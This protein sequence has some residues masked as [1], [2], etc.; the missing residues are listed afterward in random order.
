VRLRALRLHDVRRF[1]GEGIALEGVADGLNCLIR[2]NEFGKTTLLEAFEALL[3]VKHGSRAKEAAGLKPRAGGAP[4]VSADIDLPDARVTVRKR[5]LSRPMAQVVDR[6]TGAVI[7]NGDA[8][9]DWLSA[10]IGGAGKETPLALFWVR[11]GR[12]ALLD[13]GAATR[14][15]ALD[16]VIESEFADLTG[17]DRLRRLRERAQGEIAA[18]LTPQRR[19]P[20]ADGPLGRA[21]A[22]RDALA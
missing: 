4:T 7:A 9:Q 10:R 1:Q 8:A 6:E 15:G 20:R 12:S 3:T 14:K 11:Q 13:E 22:A 16:G 19:G 18:L 5:W 21:Q 2:P 17:G